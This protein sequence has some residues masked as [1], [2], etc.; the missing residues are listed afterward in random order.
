MP[1]IPIGVVL[2]GRTAPE[3]ISMA[4]RLEELGI[5]AAWMTAGGARPDSITTFAAIALKT[6]SIK[7]GTCIVP[8]YPRH[9]LVAAAQTQ[10]VAQL[11]PGRFRLG[12]GPSHRPSMA[13]MGINLTSPLGHLR[14]YVHIVK[15]LLQ[16]GKVD[17]DGQHYKAHDAIAAPVDVP[18]MA[19]ALQRGSFELCGE[20]ADG[21]ISWICPPA[22]LRDVALPA[23][24]DG[25]KKAGR[26]VPPLI[27]HAPV[28]VHDNADEVRAAVREQIINPR[29]PFYQRMLADAGFSE[30]ANAQWSDRMIDAIVFSGS[31]QRVAARLKE[32][33]SWGA[34]EVLVSLIPA[35]KDRSASRDR[36]LKLL[37]DVAKGKA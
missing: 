12:M 22:Y 17:F 35:G 14:E 25:A 24:R 15:E 19:S 10:V 32:L 9:P 11:A 7:L 37:A 28:C 21:A 4:Q 30:A 36:T 16:K 3:F 13:N 2:V 33:L 8:T 20:V 26:P 6:R 5:P 27:A 29:L 23:M 18:V 31:E 1:T 34:S